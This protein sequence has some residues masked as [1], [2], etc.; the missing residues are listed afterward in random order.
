MAQDYS[1]GSALAD[2]DKRSYHQ[3][4]GQLRHSSRYVAE[5][6]VFWFRT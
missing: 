2:D 5:G 6:M 4:S 3:H 1:K